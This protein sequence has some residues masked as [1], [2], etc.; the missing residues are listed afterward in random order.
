MPK[1]RWVRRV[2]LLGVLA[3]LLATMTACVEGT[4]TYNSNPEGNPDKECVIELRIVDREG[5]EST[6][7]FSHRT[8]TCKKCPVGAS[9]PSCKSERKKDEPG[10]DVRKGDK[11]AFLLIVQVVG[12][13]TSAGLKMEVWIT[14]ANGDVGRP[15]VY[16]TSTRDHTE[17]IPVQSTDRRIRV[18][19]TPK[20]SDAI[21]SCEI[22][23]PARD[24]WDDN[25]GG[26]AT[27]C[28]TPIASRYR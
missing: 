13:S 25:T 27:S 14:P 11:E 9:F 12:S 28:E 7:K 23:G 24:P 3:M 18:K 8:S 16:E 4:V 2:G 26:G 20:D 21:A 1:H 10:L 6:K 17:R 15:L 22:F 5:G 19:V